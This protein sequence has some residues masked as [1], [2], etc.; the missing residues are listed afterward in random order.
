MGKS[1]GSPNW[2][3]EKLDRA[4]ANDSWWRKFPLYKLAVKQTIKSDHDPILLE[5]VSVD[6]SRKQFR[7]KFKNTWLN[8]PDLKKMFQNIG[9]LFQQFMF[10]L[11]CFQSLLLW[12]SGEE[13]SSISPRTKSK[14]KRLFLML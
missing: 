10:S 8:E 11:N 9:V 4:F 3:R 6:I 5:T 12:R 14:N 2:V 1:K 13:I 7:F